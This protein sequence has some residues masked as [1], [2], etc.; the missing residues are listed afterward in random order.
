MRK[1]RIGIFLLW[2]IA[3]LFAVST[4]LAN[5]PAQACK[6]TCWHCADLVLLNG[7]IVTVDE[8]FSIAQAVAVKDGEIIRVGSN[9]HMRRYIRPNTRVLDL[10][11]A[12]VLPGINDSHI[13]LNAF[14][15][16]RPPLVVDVSYPTVQS[17]ADIVE[18]VGSKVNDLSPG[19]WV[20][21]S[22]WDKGFLAECL[23]DPAREPSRWDLDA[24]SP[25]NPVALMDF[26]G[27]V[28][29]VNS[30]AL[31]LAGITADTPDPPGGIIVRDGNGEPTGILLESAAWYVL[32]FIPPWTENQLK[33][34]I[35]IGMDELNSLGITSATEPGLDPGALGLYNELN[36]SG[37]LTV[38]ISAMIMG[39]NSLEDL[40]SVLE[41]I[42]TTTGYG[43]DMLQI[44]GLKL[45]ADGI[46]PSR[47]A[48][49]W[50]DYLDYPNGDP[51][52]HGSLVVAGA[53]E[54]E[55]YNTLVEMI[56]Y[57]SERGFQ[58][59]IHAT[60]DRAIDTC[61]DGYIATLDEHPWDARHY[62]I[63]GD[64]ISPETADRMA[65]YGIHT[66]VQPSIKWTIGNL[67][68]GIVGQ[69]R[70]EYQ[71]PL[72]TI[73]DHGVLIAGGSDS[74]V[75]YPDW[76]QGVESAILRE[77]KATGVVSGPEERITVEEAIRSY[78]IA[79]AWQ[80][81][82][83]DLKGSVE[84]GKLAD[85]CI[86]D[87]DILNVDPHDISDLPIM[88]TILGGEVVYDA[89]LGLEIEYL[90]HRARRGRSRH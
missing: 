16:S 26:S 78:T 40:Q 5:D 24:V 82:M 37:D 4:L 33:Q 75:T 1:R 14:G 28:Q 34:G 2:G 84:A 31:E 45:F 6:R 22:G 86:I 11:G 55:R 87:G 88:M 69:E 32:A 9:R 64:Y 71:W 63:H 7:N 73:L 51:G 39:P 46:P 19:E 17:I 60:G 62:I 23:A 18:A 29:W 61:V 52:G 90:H 21:G 30:K 79:G 85:F 47:T 70:A 20:Q 56:K 41:D 12:T 77:D 15:L 3:L 38:R 83:E 54:E 66:S 27:H 67:M 65:A 80:D 58:V 89:D 74:P 49:M 44:A 48:Y 35:I 50:D 76:R 81:H 68:V 43:D 42:D 13:H 8:D 10:K 36:D 25:D 53:T 59:G 72:R 57:G